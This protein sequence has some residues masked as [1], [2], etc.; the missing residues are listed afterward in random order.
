ML[1]YLGSHALHAWE[2]KLLQYLNQLLMLIDLIIFR[3]VYGYNQ[4]V[5][6]GI[7]TMTSFGKRMGFNADRSQD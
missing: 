2:G 6:S 5:F 7:L 4:G 1:V 3:F